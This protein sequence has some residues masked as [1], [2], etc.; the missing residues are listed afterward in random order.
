MPYTRFFSN[1]WTIAGFT[2][3]LYST[4]FSAF[5]LETAVLKVGSPVKGE[6]SYSNSENNIEPQPQ[7]HTQSQ[8]KPQ[9]KSLDIN[10]PCDKGDYLTGYVDSG[11]N[12]M[13]MDIIDATG[14]LSRR[15]ID[16]KT[17]KQ[18]FYSVAENCAE[19]WR[20]SGI[21]EYQIVLEQRVS[22]AE[23]DLEGSLESHLESSDALLSPKVS[24]LRESLQKG[25]SSDG[26]WANVE[27]LGTPLIE[28][29]P[30]GTLMTFL[31]RGDYR[32]IKLMGGP[33]NN[34]DAL[35]RLAD[36][37]TWY[38]SFIVPN[39]THLSYQIAPNV[40]QLP[41]SGRAR[42]IA[43]KAVAQADPYNHH[44]WPHSAIDKYATK[45]TVTLKDAPKNP[46][47]D[48]QK[49]TPKGE[50]STFK[51]TSSILDN[52]RDITIYSPA[53]DDSQNNRDDA[54]LL[55]IFDAESY[56]DT[57]GLPTILD[58]LIEE[59]EIPPVTAV[60]ISNPDGDARAREL[61]ANPVFADVLANELV[62]QVN[63]R[64]P[65]AIP[66]DRTVIAG[67]SYGGLAAT[68]IALRH[69]DIFGNVISM[70]GSFWWKPEDQ[71]A[72][73]K[74]F[75]ASEVIRMDKAPVRFFMSA[76]VF[77]TARGESSSNGIL[78]TNRHLRDV[79][80][81][82]GYYARY[83]EYGAGHDYFSWRGIIADGL[84]SLFGSKE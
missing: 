48:V 45:S 72:D 27:A 35:Q 23:Q 14:K 7:P 15:L 74:H 41:L 31:A 50:L 3:L 4:S 68:T 26:F 22:L 65:V 58:N 60:F 44:P 21:G 37:D 75:V 40:P 9:H 61:P 12:T 51:F 83:E 1:K 67:S 71:A 24:A 62:P 16:H 42:R 17:G 36:S 82:K 29:T 32:N 46:W 47:L 66:K 38:K 64:L 25:Q 56:I 73:D 30:S 5:G 77:E 76:G 2:C 39:N 79:L 84:I 49:E 33:S 6:L 81:A 80:L 53:I 18:K 13:T 28:E 78:G 20:L 70:S 54:V 59:G 69:P 11:D 34:H 57:V 43:I 10:V 63:K 19:I 52:T 55:Y 8:S